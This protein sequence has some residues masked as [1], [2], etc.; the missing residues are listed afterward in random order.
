MKLTKIKQIQVKDAD[1]EFTVVQRK[2]RRS[3]LQ[4]TFGTAVS[5]EVKGITRYAHLHVFGFEPNTTEA[6][7]TR[8]L[9]K[10]GINKIKIEQLKSRRPEEY[11]SYKISVPLEML[12]EAQKPS[13][14]P[15]GVKMNRFL[16][17]IWLKSQQKT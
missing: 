13:L 7:I 5:E 14:W 6:N 8:Y 16:E 17:R 4:T 12:E 9:S 1:T 10:K 15:T 11:A 2:R 3:Q